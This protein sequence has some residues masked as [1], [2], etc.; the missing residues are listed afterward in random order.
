MD[1]AGSKGQVVWRNGIP[2]PARY[3][4]EQD[5]EAQLAAEDDPS[6]VFGSFR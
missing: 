6:S 3:W 5:L 4:A 1:P 2:A